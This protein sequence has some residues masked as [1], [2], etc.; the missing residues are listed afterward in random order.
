MREQDSETYQPGQQFDKS[1][2]LREEQ[3]MPKVGFH[4]GG[5]QHR[6][7]LLWWTSGRKRELGNRFRS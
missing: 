7:L 3:A 1:V 5:E 2:P 4:Y 6:Y